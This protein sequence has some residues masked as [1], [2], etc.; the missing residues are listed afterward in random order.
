MTQYLPISLDLTTFIAA[1]DS[2]RIEHNILPDANMPGS[3]VKDASICPRSPAVVD[4][5]GKGC[6]VAEMARSGEGA[7]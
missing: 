2:A 3:R 7:C 5:A 4:H 6:V 1:L